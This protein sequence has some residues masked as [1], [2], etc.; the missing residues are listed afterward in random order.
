MGK[1]DKTPF[2]PLLPEPGLHRMQIT[3]IHRLLGSSAFPLSRTRDTL[4]NG[5]HS[6]IRS[7]ESLEIEAALWLDGSFLETKIDPDDVDVIL[8][9]SSLDCSR[10]S[11]DQFDFLS[12]LLDEDKSKSR[13]HCHVFHVIDYPCD[14]PQHDIGESERH[15]WR[16]FF[17]RTRADI[18]KGFVRIDVCRQCYLRDGWSKSGSRYNVRPSTSWHR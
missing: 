6:L 14:H 18:P 16:R 12:M 9:L 17:G 15:D 11:N 8:R 13:F 10:F 3:G 5:L 7:L 4:L 2:P 1:K